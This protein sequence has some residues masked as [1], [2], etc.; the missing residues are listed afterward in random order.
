MC[1]SQL[2]APKWPKTSVLAG[3]MKLC[4]H[5]GFTSSVEMNGLRAE[6]NRQA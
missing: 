5:L 2:A 3:L 1:C 4:S 6:C